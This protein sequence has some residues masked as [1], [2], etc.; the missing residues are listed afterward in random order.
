MS[1]KATVAAVANVE[2]AAAVL[3]HIREHIGGVDTVFHEVEAE[4]VAVD[5]HHVP[6]GK[7]HKCHTLVTT[8]MSDSRMPKGAGVAFGELVMRLPPDWPMGE[9]DLQEDGAAWPL[10]MLKALGRLPHETGIAYDF[11]LCVDGGLPFEL[12]ADTGFAG[13][14]L[15]PPVT[16]PDAFW[17]L[18]A[19]KGKVI[20]FFGVV[21]LYPDEMALAKNEGVVALAH[22]LDALKVNELLKPGRKSAA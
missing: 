6:P 5:I 7:G 11:G 2:A 16:I 1:K 21:M 17:C 13:V 19:S 22:K 4:S 14:L 20:D 10:A 15:A 8:G 12:A 3:E 18:E 9:K